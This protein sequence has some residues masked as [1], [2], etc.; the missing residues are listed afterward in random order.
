MYLC[1]LLYVV[2][3]V[4]LQNGLTALNYAAAGGSTDVVDLLLSLHPDMI[5]QT[6]NVSEQ[7]TQ[8]S[9]FIHD[10]T[11]MM[12]E[13]LASSHDSL[14]LGAYRINLPIS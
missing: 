14:I 13:W 3:C 11:W 9:I 12:M 7:I 2:F 4:F 6:D 8:F 1:N 5:A 10:H